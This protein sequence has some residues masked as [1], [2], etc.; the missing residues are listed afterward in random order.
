MKT[1]DIMR[2]AGRNLRQAKGRTFLTSLA[3]AV[4]AFT[5]TLSLA[6]GEGAR[7]YADNLLKN[8]IDPQA[9]F[10]VKD[11][12]ITSTS[13]SSNIQEYSD[14][15]TVSSGGAAVKMITQEDITKLES[16]SDIE[17][18]V[19]VYQLQ[20]KYIV[21]EGINKRYSAPITYYDSST[22]VDTSAGTV[23]TLGTQIADDEIL[24][25]Q[26][27]VDTLNVRAKDLIGKKLTVT[28]SQTTATPTTEQ[29]TQAFATGGDE[30]VKDLTKPQ[31]KDFVY[32]IRGIIK[33]SPMA[34]TS[35]PR[36]HVSTNAAKAINDYAKTG[37]TDANKFYGATALAK[38]GYDPTAVKKAIQH[39]YG[40][41]VQTAEDAQSLLFTFVNILQ[42]IVVGFA[43]LALVASVFGIINTQYI[44]VLERTSQIGLMKA[45]GMRRRD[46]AKLFRYEAAWIG[47]IGGALGVG[48][49]LLVG[50][51]TNPSI[52]KALNLGDSSLLIFVWWQLAILIVALIVVAISAGWLPARKAAR[53]DPIEALRTE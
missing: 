34:I 50:W 5:L 17:H 1:I 27:F 39:D 3:I 2:R 22:L 45:L 38:K 31:T 18:V 44:S 10:I 48:L 28:V 43:M 23:P 11:S 53:L 29:I 36:L 52:T 41:T 51:A 14:A 20:A 49:G 47:F 7:Q 40:Y 13:A 12:K 46:I 33:T 32:T 24:V 4:G 16:R 30:A 19:P 21:F 6:A 35:N 25:P 26:E 37:S 42:G 15:T 9:L 8:N